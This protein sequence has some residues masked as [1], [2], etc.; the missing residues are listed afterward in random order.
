MQAGEN[1]KQKEETTV[2]RYRLKIGSLGR[3]VVDRYF[4]VEYTVVNAYKNI[5]RCVVEHY[6]KIETAFVDAF[7]EEEP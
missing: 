3:A 6:K 1:P 5:E 4:D 2:K 7:L